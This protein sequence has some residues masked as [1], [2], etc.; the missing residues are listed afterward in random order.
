MTIGL[1][2]EI[3]LNPNPTEV[4]GSVLRCGL[5]VKPVTSSTAVWRNYVV[6]LAHAE[7]RNIQ[8]I[9]ELEYITLVCAQL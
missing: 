7:S 4:T 3:G 8:R 1:N 2:G 6:K 5:G 9:P